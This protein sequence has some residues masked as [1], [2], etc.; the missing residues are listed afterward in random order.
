MAFNLLQ[1][2][3]FFVAKR[4]PMKL[5][6]TFTLLLI[7]YIS[8]VNAQD[9]LQN[10]KITEEPRIALND[11]GSA[12]STFDGI[13]AYGVDRARIGTFE[14]AG[15]VYLAKADCEGW[16]VYQELTAPAPA[17]Y[18]G[19]GNRVLLKDDWLLI[20]GAGLIFGNSSIYVFEKGDDDMFILRQRIDHPEGNVNERFG[21]NF[22]LGG[23]TMVITATNRS[24]VGS[25]HYAYPLT[26]G[27]AYS[28]VNNG[29]G[30]W[31]YVQKIEASDGEPLDHFGRSISIDD[32]TMV[33]GAP[34][35]GSNR[36]GAAYI[37]VKNVATNTWN[38]IK[39]LVSDDYRGLQ[40]NYGHSVKIEDNIIAVSSYQ[41]KNYNYDSLVPGVTNSNGAVYLYRTDSNSNWVHYQKLTIT[42]ATALELKFGSGLEL[43]KDQLAVG[44]QE[45]IYDNT[46]V[47]SDMDA[48]VYMFR[49]DGND[50]WN[51][52]E[53]IDP[54]QNSTTY[55]ESISIYEQDM[56][57]SARWDNYDAD[58][59]NYISSSGSVYLYNTYEFE[60]TEKPVLKAS[61]TIRACADLG[62]GFSSG[63][64]LSNVEESLAENINDYVFYYWDGQGNELPSPLPAIYANSSP[65][66]ETI[67]V[68]I[69]NK[70]NAHCFEESE[71]KLET[72]SPFEL[73]EIPDLLACGVDGSSFGLFDISSLN[74]MLV[75]DPDE[76]TFL[77]YNELGNDI[78]EAIASPYRNTVE[79]REELNIIVTHKNTSCTQEQTVFL[80][81]VRS[82]AH[83]VPE[84]YS[85]TT[86]VNGMVAFDTSGIRN[87]LLGDQTNKTIQFFDENNVLL[88]GPLPNPYYLNPDTVQTITAVVQ[89]VTHGCST[90]TFITFS[91]TD[92][93]DDREPVD[94]SP[95]E[96]EDSLS[97][98]D[99][100]PFFTP[101][102]DGVNET[103]FITS[104]SKVVE[105]YV[106]HIFDRYGKLLEMMN[107]N[108]SWDGRY[109]GHDMPSSDYWYKVTLNNLILTSGHFTLKR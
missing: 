43:Y 64:D 16:S 61:P 59:K 27:W 21:F 2:N 48:K 96:E 30:N 47:L 46:G 51:P 99:I 56:F 89:D 107:I 78:S 80:N 82:V 9:W 6:Q 74:E 22:D 72:I 5:N 63:F 34:R 77:Y 81:V 88:N 92:C 25:G 1:R 23:N 3:A 42:D 39:K 8:L 104:N 93:P 73:N 40:M 24:I 53:V 38:E 35:E 65:Y 4:R 44:G 67:S 70:N 57:V 45:L 37:F 95:T 85:C 10:F 101:N 19:F 69:E 26:Q 7:F 41:D 79:N 83:E 60:P 66:S 103:W 68:R 55:G 20:S 58:D 29:D 109:Q 12:I 76:Y 94:N 36:S 33:I 91:S 17:D 14:K 31:Q 106:I 11:F 13:V 54:N 84:L 28:Y 100:P 86:A 98:L 97:L 52:Y 90:E 108:N 32:N 15:K 75:S 71:I 62:N 105:N 18:G 49:K 87:Q 50:F 102:S